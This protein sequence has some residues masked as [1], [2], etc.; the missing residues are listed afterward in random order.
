MCGC[1]RS[2]AGNS[3]PVVSATIP[4]RWGSTV[5]SRG[6][7]PCVRE[8]HGICGS[9]VPHRCSEVR[10]QSRHCAGF[11]SGGVG[12]SAWSR[13]GRRHGGEACAPARSPT[14]LGRCSTPN[15][16]L[17]CRGCRRLRVGVGVERG[18]PSLREVLLSSSTQGRRTPT[19]PVTGKGGECRVGLPVVPASTSR[20]S[21]FTWN[22]WPGAAHLRIGTVL[23]WSPLAA[24]PNYQ[25]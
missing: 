6:V 13:G 18:N 22:A 11:H 25:G 9:C 16:R 21:C 1:C 3:R 20:A 15:P 23:D 7:L 10:I 8:V 5:H 2:D 17:R 19:W 12:A 24:G 4:G 14:I